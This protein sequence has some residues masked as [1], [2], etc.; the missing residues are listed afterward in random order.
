MSNDK[1]AVRA[2]AVG[3]DFGADTAEFDPAA[4][5]TEAVEQDHR[6][7]VMREFESYERIVEG[8]KIASDGARNMARFKNP[9]LWN[10]L[11]GFLDQL[12]KAMVKEAGF[13]RPEDA[14]ESQ[15]AFGGNMSWTTAS[16]RV[17]NGLKDA[18]G[19]ARQ[20]A[21]GQRMD[22]RWTQYANRLDE[23]RDKAHEMAL[24]SSP[25]AVAAKWG[26]GTASIQ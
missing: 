25:L 22:L 7:T 4:P 5:V 18:A 3:Q 20:I 11:A 19:G 24:A 15:Q 14:R 21:L 23:M 10:K 1:E 26:G 8:L 12:R 17:A 2:A 16:S 9:D 13:D 6:G